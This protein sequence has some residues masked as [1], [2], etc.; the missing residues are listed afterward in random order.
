ML[1][2]QPK[3]LALG[4]SQARVARRSTLARA[5]TLGVPSRK[6]PA[7][8]L[9]PAPRGALPP[10]PRVAMG[11][12]RRRRSRPQPRAPRRLSSA[13][14]PTRRTT[15]SYPRLSTGWSDRIPDAH[16]RAA[17]AKAL[18][19]LRRRR[20]RAST[21]RTTSRRLIEGLFELLIDEERG[22]CGARVR[23]PRSAS[24]RAYGR[25]RRTKARY[26]RDVR[27]AVEIW[28]GKRVRRRRRPTERR[29]DAS[30]AHPRPVP[31]QG[32]R[33][34]R[35]GVPARRALAG[36]VT[37][38]NGRSAAEGLREAVLSHHAGVSIKPHVI[39]ITG[40]L[41]RVSRR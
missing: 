14:C 18:R 16:V 30:A 4:P 23:G 28:R 7:P 15:C 34:R 27:G 24:S 26:L 38:T 39:P 41:I 5:A 11:S 22:I 19:R 35:A 25:R 37:P 31:P 40:P 12:E 6:S 32:P 9:A 21:R 29:F 13:P 33:A 20:P 1:R 8:A 10:A 36:A 2:A 3:I 17:A